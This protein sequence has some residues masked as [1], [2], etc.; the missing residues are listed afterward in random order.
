MDSCQLALAVATILYIEEQARQHAG[1]GD[2]KAFIANELGA[3]RSQFGLDHLAI[4]VVKA[5][6]A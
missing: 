3:I 4:V 1:D 2:H 5:R 6:I